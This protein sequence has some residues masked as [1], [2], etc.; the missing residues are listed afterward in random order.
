MVRRDAFQDFKHQ[1]SVLVSTCSHWHSFIATTTNKQVSQ[2]TGSQPASHLPGFR[3]MLPSGPTI[4]WG[5]ALDSSASPSFL[6]SS[7]SSSSASLSRS[8]RRDCSAAAAAVG[9]WAA[10]ADV[11]DTLARDGDLHAIHSTLLTKLKSRAISGCKP[12]PQL[13]LLQNVNTAWYCVCNSQLQNLLTMHLNQLK[14]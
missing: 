8:S 3:M 7:S 14:I 2:Q 12:S 13:Y 9:G 11:V 5:T 6:A 10:D 4:T 1:L